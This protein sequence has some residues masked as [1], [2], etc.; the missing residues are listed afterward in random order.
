MLSHVKKLRIGKNEIIADAIFLI[1]AML[2]SFIALF[3]FDIHWSFYPGNTIFPPNKYIFTDNNI[4]YYGTLAGGIVGFFILKLLAYG[5]VKEEENE[6]D[7]YEKK[8]E[9]QIKGKKRI[10]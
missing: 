8:L 2:L 7:K 4:F 9:K 10:R 6:L 3:I 1:V 5:L